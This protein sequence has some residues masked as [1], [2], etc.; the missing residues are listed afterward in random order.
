MS[1]RDRFRRR[2][3]ACGCNHTPKCPHRAA[4]LSWPLEP[5]TGA[6]ERAKGP[7]WLRLTAGPDT[8][9]KWERSGLSDVDAD[10]W[11]VRI[12]LHPNQ[13]W[14]RWD[15]AGLRAVDAVFVADGWRHAW[16]HREAS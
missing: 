16:E 5:L 15:E 1:Y 11:A 6:C 13:V 10:R 8:F 4:V 2:C 7:G 9:A 12:G 14:P 3:S